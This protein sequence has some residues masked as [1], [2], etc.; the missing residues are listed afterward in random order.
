MMTPLLIFFTYLF[1]V[2]VIL[3]LALSS[4]SL[5]P[6]IT[7]ARVFGRLP[8][9]ESRTFGSWIYV[10]HGVAGTFSGHFPESGGGGRTAGVD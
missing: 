2:G 8:V 5:K 1:F 10:R 6:G 4:N 3:T 9:T 7:L